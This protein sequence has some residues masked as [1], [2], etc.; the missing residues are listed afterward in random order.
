MSTIQ[1]RDLTT[2]DEFRQVVALERAIWGYTDIGDLVTVPVFTFTVQARR[3]PA[4]RVRRRA[5]G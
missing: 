1:I 3:D 5:V 4:R 2:I